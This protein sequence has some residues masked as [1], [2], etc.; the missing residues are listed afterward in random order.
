[1]RKLILVCFSLPA[2]FA[3]NVQLLATL[4][5]HA[6][7]RAMQLDASGNIFLAGSFTPQNPTDPSDAFV[8]KVSADGS[9]VLYFTPLSGISSDTAAG[10]AVGSDGSAYVVGSTE[11]QNF[12]VTPG[13]IQKTFD[14]RGA[15]QGFLVKVNPAGNIVYSTYINGAA[16]TELTG[17]TLDQAGNVYVTGTGGPGY[18]ANSNQPAE[19]F[20]VKIDPGLSAYQLSEYG[21]GGGLIA[22]DSQGNLYLAGTAIPTGFPNPVLPAMPDGAFQTTHAAAVCQSASGGPSPGFER[23]CSY[24]FVAKLDPAGKLLWGTYVTGTYGAI[25]AGMAVDS[26]GNVIVAGT[27]NSSD[28]PVTPGA[29]QTAYLAAGPMPPNNSLNF[30]P[31]NSTGYVTKVNSGGT[32]LAWST[33]FGGT[34]QDQITGMAIMPSAEILVSGRAASADL[35]FA[36]TPDGC[37]PTANQVLGFVA[38]LSAD[39]SSVAATQPVAGAP[40]CLYVACSDLDFYRT[41]WPVALRPDGTVVTAGSSGTVASI[42]FSTS[43]RVACVTDPADNAQLRSVTPGQLIS[44]FGPALASPAPFTPPGGVMQSTNTFGVFFNGIPAPILYSEAQQINVQVPY[45]IEGS[46]T[47]QMQVVNQNVASPVSETRTLGVAERQPA[48]FLSPGALLS[49]IPQCSVCGDKVVF[50]Q[51]ALALNADGTLNDCTNPATVGSTVTIFLNGMGTVIPAQA[52]GAIAQAPPT[53]L[54]PGLDPGPFTGTVSTG[55]ATVP[56]AISGLA[57]A[58]LV[59]TGATLLNEASVAGVQTRDRVIMIWVK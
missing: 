10:I 40:D 25:P 26:G 52:T 20:V 38:R 57:Q 6:T 24:Q 7:S 58:H 15:S 12:P 46:A 39:G 51:T 27:T 8:A 36:D 49:P 23:F 59:N 1:M 48:V 21:Y 9:K 56:G 19:G 17:I 13:A 45:E 44:L 33:Y 29:F 16:F 4:P 30:G 22:L 5:N 43:P 34:S 37:R 32:S 53:A 55:T 14:T 2:A 54:M 11:S 41:G 47:V 3:G 28:Y 18:P 35:F 31:P 50:G 42:D